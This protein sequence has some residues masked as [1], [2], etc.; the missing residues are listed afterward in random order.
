MNVKQKAIEP[1]TI[2]YSDEGNTGLR[3]YE[4]GDE[5]MFVLRERPVEDESSLENLLY[6]FILIAQKLGY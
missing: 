6:R 2:Q 5:N 3:S 1:S 4:I